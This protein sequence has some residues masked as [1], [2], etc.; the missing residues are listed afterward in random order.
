MPDR[1]L[2]GS[3]RGDRSVGRS[4][5]VVH[6]ALGRMP[7]RLSKRYS[8]TTETIS[9]DSGRGRWTPAWKV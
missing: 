7:V 9:G 6:R 4:C 5:R 2:V 3:G 1:A 8:R